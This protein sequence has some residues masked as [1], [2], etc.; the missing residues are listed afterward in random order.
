VDVGI[1]SSPTVVRDG[2]AVFDSTGSQPVLLMPSPHGFVLGPTA[3]GP[4]HAVLVAL[5]LRVVTFDPPGAFSSTRRPTLSLQE[6]TQCSLEA[7]DCLG[8][9]GPV[10][11]VAHSHA[12][13]CALHL[14]LNRAER[15]DRLLLVGAV[16]G[17]ARVT[18]ADGGLPFSLSW[19]DRRFWR[20][21]WLGTRL[22]VRGDLAAHR[23]LVALFQQ[24]SY[25]DHAMAPR[26]VVQPGDPELPAP[27]RDR[28][29][30][31]I[32]RV[33]L[34]PQLSA[35]PQATL[36][37]VG[38]HDPQTPMAANAAVAAALPH[39]RLVVF[40]HSGHYPF[41]EE[42]DGFAHVAA[43]FLCENPHLHLE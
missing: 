24:L 30:R 34:R 18:R 7:L 36:V 12:T 39:G 20:I 32:R 31:S 29:Q 26:V 17:G 2:L 42:P 22:A 8:I 27:V 38:R 16:A 41:V 9:R 3:S 40:E 21:A 6:M 23:N 28:W 19:R 14:A 4:L 15:V 33:D 35:L 37:C 5:G 1:Q 43:Q 11:V 13:L 10:P 25:V